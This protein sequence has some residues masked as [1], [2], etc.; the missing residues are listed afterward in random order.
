MRI[1]DSTGSVSSTISPTI[2][3]MMSSTVTI[4]AVRPYSSTITAIEERWRCMSASRSSSGLVSGMIGA[5]RTERLDRRIG[6]L[7]H[8]RLGEPVGVHDAL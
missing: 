8:Q 5:S 7:A 1:D 3:S 2:S 6:A 4:P